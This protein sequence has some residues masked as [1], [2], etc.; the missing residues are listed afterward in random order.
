MFKR[1][2][3]ELHNVLSIILLSLFGNYIFGLEFNFDYDFSYLIIFKT[4]VLIISSVLSYSIVLRL[5]KNNEDSIKEFY[6]E[7]D[8]EKKK[9]YSVDKI[10]NNKVQQQSILLNCY[11]FLAI[12]CLALFFLIEPFIN[13]LF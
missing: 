5:K 10:Y 7:K 3:I 8:E 1:R 9:I 12:L 6:E 4:I 13:F 2:V 11:F